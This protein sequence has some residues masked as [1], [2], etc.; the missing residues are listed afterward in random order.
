VVSISGING[1]E[2]LTARLHEHRAVAAAISTI[3]IFAAFIGTLLQG[4]RAHKLHYKAEIDKAYRLAT[5][6][7]NEG[8]YMLRPVYAAN[9]DIA[10]FMIAD[11]NE[12][13]AS[14]YGTTREEAL[15]NLMSSYF[16]DGFAEN[17]LPTYRK[18]M[19]TGFV[20]G[21]FKPSRHSTLRP[22]WVQRRIFRSGDGL[23]VT[24]RDITE[25]KMYE[26]DL[27][28]LANIDPVTSLPNRHWLMNQMPK[29]L[30]QAKEKNRQMA[31]LFV[32][33]DDFKLVNDTL[34][35]AIGDVLLNLV[36]TR[37]K[38]AVRP[39]DS[40]VRLGGDE[41]TVIL[42]QISSDDEIALC[43]DRIIA[44]LS[45]PFILEKGRA[46]TVHASIGISVFPRDGQDP[47]T[48]LK[49]ADIAMYAVKEN[50]KHSAQFFHPHLSD[51]IVQRQA[52]LQAIERGID[53]DEFVLY[54]QPR[55]DTQT[56]ELLSME[57]LLRWI[58]PQIGMVSP[59]KFIPFAEESGLISALGEIVIRKSCEHLAEWRSQ[60]LS[61]KPIS[62]NVSPYQFSKGK[63]STHLASYLPRHVIAPSLIEVEITES[64]M[65]GEEHEVA[66]ELAAIERL[67]IK[68]AVDDFGTGYSSLSQLKR[69]NVSCLK[70]D[71]SLTAQLC[72]GTDDEAFFRGIVSM[73]HAIN[74]SVVAEGVETMEQLLILQQLSCDEVQGYFIS[75]PVPAADVPHLIRRRFFYPLH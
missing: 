39:E 52:M 34:G 64:A 40:V 49:H 11:C 45:H 36:A 58:D 14:Y 4:R 53:N 17:I 66:Q 31:L 5:D 48:L 18:A 68:M 30:D 13:G 12:K 67:G 65:L 15:G 29:L 51:V 59:D 73:A 27:V 47:E 19:E 43:A 55:V 44:A 56:G 10:D 7:A 41:F 50:G 60:G 38:T 71:Q 24:V 35:H 57:A 54:F 1:S 69:L 16:K 74:I 26:F 8:F 28:R 70:V 61:V 6:H 3:L 63:I 22:E 33:L 72:T 46:N 42:E 21:E 25:K 62:I 2:L 75:R 9:G 23:A 32:D 37:L 20:E